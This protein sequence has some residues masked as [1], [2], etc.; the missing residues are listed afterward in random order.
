MGLS[1]VLGLLG[2]LSGLTKHRNDVEREEKLLTLR[3]QRQHCCNFDD[4]YDC[5]MADHG[6]VAAGRPVDTE[7]KQPEAGS[8]NVKEDV[9]R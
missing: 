4:D 7:T 8:E 6:R 5:I 1:F 9:S 2:I 3:I